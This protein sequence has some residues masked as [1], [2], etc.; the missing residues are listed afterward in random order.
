MWERFRRFT[1][2]NPVVRRDRITQCPLSRVVCNLCAANHTVARSD[3]P[4]TGLTDRFVARGAV[5]GLHTRFPQPDITRSASECRRTYYE[6]YNVRYIDQL[7]V[8]QNSMLLMEFFVV[9]DT[10]FLHI[11]ILFRYVSVCVR[12][13]VYPIFVRPSFPMMK[14]S[15]GLN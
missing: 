14:Y 6:Q 5:V 11:K 2:V 9:L 12:T 10:L 15:L 3:N 13:C 4:S 1:V 8:Q 7:E